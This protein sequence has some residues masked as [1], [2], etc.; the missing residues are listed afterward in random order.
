MAERDDSE[1]RDKAYGPT[2]RVFLGAAAAAGILAQTAP[3]ALAATTA[4]QAKAGAASEGAAATAAALPSC[5]S[6]MVCAFNSDGTQVNFPTSGNH[7][8]WLSFNSVVG[9]N[10]VSIINNSGSDIWLYDFQAASSAS[11]TGGPFPAFGTSLRQYQFNT[12]VPVSGG[13][14]TQGYTE[15]TYRPGWFFVQFG[16]NTCVGPVPTPLPGSSG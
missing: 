1:G 2:R 6:G 15:T 13:T 4:S 9:F 8:Q 3:H 14:S 7:S 10:P 5:P 12:W 16:V 11:R